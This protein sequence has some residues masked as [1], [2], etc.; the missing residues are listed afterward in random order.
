VS[1]LRNALEQLATEIGDLR[2]AL[3]FE[4][5]GIDVAT[6]GDAEFES[7]TTELAA[8]W[9]SFSSAEV[10]SSLGASAPN[11]LEV[12]VQSEAWMLLPVGKGYLLGMLVGPDGL[13]A[14]ARFYG[15]EWAHR[16]KEEFS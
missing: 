8:L 3:V 10:V 6:W 7:A 2:A 11:Y 13:P 5:S 1:D 9:R 16:H 15:A 4:S 14:R 12:R